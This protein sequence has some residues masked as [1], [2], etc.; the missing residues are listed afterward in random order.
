MLTKNRIRRIF[1]L[2]TTPFRFIWWLLTFVEPHYDPEKEW[3][4]GGKIT[5]AL[6]AIGAGI[7]IMLSL[8]NGINPFRILFFY[9]LGGIITSIIIRGGL[10]IIIALQEWW[11]N[12]PEGRKEKEKFTLK[13]HQQFALNDSEIAEEFI[14]DKNGKYS[15]GQR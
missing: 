14:E 12:L 11:E 5:L 15:A 9:S 7:A 4:D 6:L 3:K 1:R 10:W 2:I 13:E 8:V